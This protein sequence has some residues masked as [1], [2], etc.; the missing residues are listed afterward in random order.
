[1]GSKHKKGFVMPNTTNS[2]TPTVTKEYIRDIIDKE[3]GTGY[4]NNINLNG[5]IFTKNGSFIVFEFKYIDDIKVCHIKYIYFKNQKDFITIM[6]N[7]CNFWMGN[8]VQFIFYKEK[9]KDN[10]PVPFLESLNFRKE[11][12]DYPKYKWRFKCVKH[13]YKCVCPVYSL[14][15]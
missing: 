7:C 14:F 12:I 3:N 6:T 9:Q 10:S 8:K 15:K 4:S 1:M 5:Y 13:G 2:E 11:V